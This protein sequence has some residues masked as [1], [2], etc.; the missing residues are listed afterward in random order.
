MALQKI[1]VDTDAIVAEVGRLTIGD[2]D[3]LPFGAIQLDLNGTVLLYN[4][5]EERISGRK[6]E[7][8]VGR[9]FFVD[10]AP[11]TRVRR[12]YGAFQTGIERKQLNEVFDFTFRFPEGTRE[13]R[14]RMIYATNPR[15]CVWIFVTPIA[16]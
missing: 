3:A 2:L 11:C 13:V 12:F 4:K 15:A 1:D 16:M 8:V 9:N 5:T 6:R 7:D 14:I 10:I